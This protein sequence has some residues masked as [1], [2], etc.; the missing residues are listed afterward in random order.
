MGKANEDSPASL[1]LRRRADGEFYQ[2]RYPGRRDTTVAIA[3][4]T[5]V[6]RGSWLKTFLT[7]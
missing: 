3:A 5:A 4:D 7:D 1:F 2:S 6:G